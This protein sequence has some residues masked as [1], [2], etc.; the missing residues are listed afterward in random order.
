MMRDDNYVWEFGKN[1]SIFNR[2]IRVK[3]MR[4]TRKNLNAKILT[5]YHTNKKLDVLAV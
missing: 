3:C 1:Y 5:S 4:K 2:S